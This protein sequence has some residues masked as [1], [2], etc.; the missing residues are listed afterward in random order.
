MES[1]LAQDEGEIICRPFITLKNGQKIF[2]AQRG[3]KA[4]CFRVKSIR[5]Q[6]PKDE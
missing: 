3:L 2:A 6:K 1:K 4:F 5:A